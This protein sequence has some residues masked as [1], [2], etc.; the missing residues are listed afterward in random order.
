M[1][2]GR[3]VTI[4]EYNEL[5]TKLRISTIKMTSRS[6]SS[7]VGSSLSIC[8]LLAVL[9]GGIMHVDPEKPDW[10][11]RDRFVLSKGHAC[12]P[13]YAVLA[14]K[15]FFS[16][17]W[18]E[19]YCLDGARLPG[20]ITHFNIPGVEVS[21]GSL[22]HGLPVACGMALAGKAD[23]DPYRVF[24]LLSDG[25]FD[26][27]ST[28]EG[29]LFA[30]HHNLDNLV[31]IIDYNKLQ[32]CG[33]V[34][35]VLGLE[36]LAD[37]LLAFGWSVIEIDGHDVEKIEQVLDSVPFTRGKPSCIIAHTVK[38]KGVS[39]ME[40][41]VVSHYRYLDEEQLQEALRALGEAP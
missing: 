17:E 12:A 38:G 4:Q 32:A 27:G 25:E 36:P 26:E 11:L 3:Q 23:E 10:P 14:I 20:H 19:S 6:G 13:V 9:Y 8:D 37:K 28:W 39:I 29:A 1:K 22:G 16:Q 5:A 15:G 24:V 21:T 30:S 2:D 31:I 18:L 35:S 7:H 41:R 33:R 34:A 40:D